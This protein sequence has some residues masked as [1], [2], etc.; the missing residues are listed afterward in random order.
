M[1]QSCLGVRLGEYRPSF[2]HQISS[3]LSERDPEICLA[4]ANSEKLLVS[5]P[6]FS[7]RK[8][9]LLCTVTQLPCCNVNA[10]EAFSKWIG[11][12]LHLTVSFDRAYCWRLS[13]E[14]WLNWD[15]Y[16]EKNGGGN[17]RGRNGDPGSQGH[18]LF[19]DI[20]STNGFLVNPKE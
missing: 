8:Y 19:T 14:K 18:W 6:R 13:P 17:I 16:V 4:H 12:Q 5:A 9:C 11:V 1:S 20:G 7:L 2:L 15:V 3:L 10:P